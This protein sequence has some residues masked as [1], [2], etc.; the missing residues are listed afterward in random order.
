M[1]LHAQESAQWQA[2]AAGISSFIG[3]NNTLKNQGG[4]IGLMQAE[5][6]EVRSVIAGGPSTH[7]N[8][9]LD[10]R[11][12][13]CLKASAKEVALGSNSVSNFDQLESRPQQSLTPNHNHNNMKQQLGQNQYASQMNFACN[14]SGQFSAL[15]RRKSSASPI[16]SVVGHGGG[17]QSALG[18]NKDM[19][20]QALQDRCNQS[21]EELHRVKKEYRA[22]EQEYEKKIALMKQEI[23]LLQLQ[24]KETESR[25]DQQRKMYE[26][27]FQALDVGVGAGTSASEADVSRGIE[28]QGSAAPGGT[29]RDGAKRGATEDVFNSTQM[30]FGKEI[31]QIQKQFHEEMQSRITELEAQL[32]QKEKDF[33]LLREKNNK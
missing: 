24:V 17:T 20:D 19:V 9:L 1:N 22:K 29:A 32:K 12:R 23:E 26:R 31:E 28:T 6:C 18:N 3:A 2:K 8:N 5:N 30:S 11:P 25:E 13:D 4:N 16:R 15:G 33:E 7:S 10:S 14:V 27:M 21:L